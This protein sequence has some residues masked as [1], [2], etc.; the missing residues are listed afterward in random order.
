LLADLGCITIGLARGLQTGA[1]DALA[2]V[3]P[4]LFGRGLAALVIFPTLA[5]SDQRRLARFVLAACSG[6][7]ILGGPLSASFPERWAMLQPLLAG[8][9][10]WAKLMIAAIA[11]SLLAYFILLVR[12]A[13][14]RTSTPAR[15]GQVFIL[16]ILAGLVVISIILWRDSSFITALVDLPKVP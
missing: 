3:A 5:L 8:G 1:V 15:P 2:P 4:Q 13:T 7:M 11:L 10:P 14:L 9:D 6:W 12:V 16:A